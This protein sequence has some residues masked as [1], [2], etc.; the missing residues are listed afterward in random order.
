MPCYGSRSARMR[1]E[2][3]G[4]PNLLPCRVDRPN[5]PLTIVVTENEGG[6]RLVGHG[7]EQVSDGDA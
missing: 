7:S 4:I 1:S 2:I 6:R 5:E 3:G